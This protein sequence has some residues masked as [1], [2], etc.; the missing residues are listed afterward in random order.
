MKR[1]LTA[2]AAALLS[3][4]LLASCSNT[5]E[6]TDSE[7]L[8]AKQTRNTDI[9]VTYNFADGAH[10]P[11]TDYS[12]YI[13]GVTE[14]S[15]SQF[16]AL[17]KE[18]S[19]SFIFSPASSVLQ[20]SLL[21]NAASGDTRQEI[22]LALGGTLTQDGLNVCSSYFKSRLENVSR[23]GQKEAPK[24]HIKL[25]G[26]M[27]IDESID[28]KTS[29]LQSAKDFYGFDVLRYDF[30]GENA[31]E[32]L[33]AYLKPYTSDSG[34]DVSKSGTLDTLGTVSINDEWL[35]SYKDS[36]IF[37]GSFE[38]A[39]GS[40]NEV[41]LCSDE[42]RMSSEKAE[43]ILKYTSKNPL[44]LVLITPKDGKSFDEYV[45]NLDGTELSALLGSI[46]ITKK[47]AA[48]FP[49]FTIGTDGKAKAMSQALSSAGLYALFSDKSSFSSL[50]YGKGAT[51]GE[52]Y[53][54]PQNFSL[55][56]T[57]IN[58]GASGGIASAELNAEKDTLVFNRPF[59]F[60]L[61]DNESNLPVYIGVYR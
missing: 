32:K 2:A 30:N 21:A 53:E 11:P 58:K 34:I 3:V 46:D 61:L 14:F 56:H 10:N 24:E 54:I 26:A 27:L 6:F 16:R 42:S 17:Y 50:S 39:Q 28:V 15:L 12:N 38:G 44:K 35:E 49:E 37:S 59:I 55:T 31:S 5:K 20:L 45:G 36:E 33:N 57:G 4:L 18:N 8:S 13:N 43:G 29:F 47:S 7:R 9:S 51:L 22:L 1:R 25:D 23:I 41:Y 19:G 60:M 52:V 48:A 40:R